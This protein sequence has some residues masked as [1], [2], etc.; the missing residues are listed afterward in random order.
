MYR[1]GQGVPLNYAKAARWYGKGY[2]KVVASCFVRQGGPPARWTSIVVILLGLLIVAV[3]QRR[4]GAAW[5][6][7]LTSALC[8][9][10]LAHELLLSPS[11]AAMR[12]RGPLGTLYL[13]FGRVLFLVLLAGG[14]AICAV[15]AVQ[16]A[17]RGS[18]RGGDQGQPPTPPEETL[19]SP[20]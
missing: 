16:V 20:T 6:W 1:K 14:S 18:K 7:A 4:W 15:L 3:P 5:P 8:A 2:G 12:A 11:F 9:V 10:M 13:G 17:V 19:E